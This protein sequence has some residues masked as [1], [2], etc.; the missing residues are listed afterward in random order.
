MTVKELIKLLETKDQEIEIKMPIFK[1][2]G[3]ISDFEEIEDI[4][5]SYG[6]DV[7]KPQHLFVI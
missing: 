5:E 1:C 2:Q 7:S 6:D 4:Y 3:V